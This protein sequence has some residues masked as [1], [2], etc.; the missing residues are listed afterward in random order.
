ML[1]ANKQISVKSHHEIGDVGTHFEYLSK[2]NHN[3]DFKI[4][5]KLRGEYCRAES[6][7]ESPIATGHWIKHENKA[8]D[9]VEFC[10]NGHVLVKILFQLLLFVIS[11]GLNDL[12]IEKQT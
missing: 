11:Y 1:F 9:A 10:V 6:C 3:D 2:V 7:A 12:P 5:N 4:L 8:E